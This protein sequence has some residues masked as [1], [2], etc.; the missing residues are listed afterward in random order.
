MQVFIHGVVEH[1]KINFVILINPVELV[2][3]QL[4]DEILPD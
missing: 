1:L 2:S 3:R 4:G